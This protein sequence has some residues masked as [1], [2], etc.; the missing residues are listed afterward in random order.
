MG[1][2]RGVFRLLDGG[3][4]QRCND[5]GLGVIYAIVPAATAFNAVRQHMRIKC[6]GRSFP[7]RFDFAFVRKR[8]TKCD[9][10]RGAAEVFNK[11]DN[12]A[13]SKLGEL[14]NGELAV[15]ESHV[16]N[17]LQVDLN[18]LLHLFHVNANGDRRYLLVVANDDRL[19][20]R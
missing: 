17:S 6:D 20:S 13:K 11:T 10:I 12:T 7:E 16:R 3:A 8:V 15:V 9:D 1:L 2:I 18:Q 19:V 5:F 14:I 4:N